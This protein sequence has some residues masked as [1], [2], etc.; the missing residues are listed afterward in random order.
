MFGEYNRDSA[1]F[2]L[3]FFSVNND[4]N[5]STA[6]R[7]SDRLPT[8]ATLSA[9]AVTRISGYMS[10]I[11]ISNGWNATIML[12]GP[13]V[14]ELGARMTVMRCVAGSVPTLGALEVSLD[15]GPK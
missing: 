2:S 14:V 3:K 1:G 7:T 9:Y 4:T 13:D 15:F 8:N 10:A 5:Q 12:E 6:E 11:C